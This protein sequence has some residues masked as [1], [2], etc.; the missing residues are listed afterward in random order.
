MRTREIPRLPT[1]PPPKPNVPWAPIDAK[2]DFE[3]PSEG[4]CGRQ[5]VAVPTFS[6]PKPGC[7]WA[8]TGSEP[9]FR[10]PPEGFCG[11]PSMRKPDSRHHA[12]GFV[13]ANRHET[14][15][16]CP[17]RGVL[18]APRRAKVG[19]AGP[20]GA[21]VPEDAK[22]RFVT[23]CEGFCGRQPCRSPRLGS[24]DGPVWVSNAASRPGAACGWVG[25][26]VGQ[27]TVHSAYLRPVDLPCPRRAEKRKGPPAAPPRG[28][29]GSGYR[30]PA[31]AARRLRSGIVFFCPYIM[32][33]RPEKVKPR[34][35][36]DH[37]PDAPPIAVRSPRSERGSE[38]RASMGPR[39]ISRG[40]ATASATTILVAMT[41]MGPRLIS[42]G[43][44]WPPTDRAT[45]PC[46]PRLI[47]RGPIEANGSSHAIGQGNN[48]FPRLIS[49]GPIE[50]R[51]PARRFR[52]RPASF[53]G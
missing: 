34:F 22:P 44:G 7:V 2:P 3:T 15:I 46:F 41:S 21:W 1:L 28:K 9:R 45:G 48:C 47:S 39:L 26:A 50:A 12:R 19:F 33:D 24:E 4:F 51:D 14:T 43:K 32:R 8:P 38:S 13:G 25:G 11:R 35:V 49:R 29:T 40:K 53:R 18:W 37:E 17:T 30:R 31:R 36:P 6:P 5:S 23:P 10:A 20:L 42:R 52:S 27:R 16:P